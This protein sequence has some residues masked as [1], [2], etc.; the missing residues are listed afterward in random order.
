VR[1][2]A[3]DGVLIKDF[4]KPGGLQ[5]DK[6]HS[7][8]AMSAVCDVAVDVYIQPNAHRS[9]LPPLRIPRPCPSLSQPVQHRGRIDPISSPIRASDQPA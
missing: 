8:A 6:P 1:N 5:F 4:T 2:R 3:S 9:P 7:H